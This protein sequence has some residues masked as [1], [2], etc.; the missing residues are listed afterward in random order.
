MLEKDFKRRS[1]FAIY[2]GRGSL[3]GSSGWDAST[4][5]HGGASN[6]SPISHPPLPTS[7][8]R[9]PFSSTT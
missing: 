3:S 5:G 2:A 1:G 4:Q 9:Q 7:S 6:I 8:N